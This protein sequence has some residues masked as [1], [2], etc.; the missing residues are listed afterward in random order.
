M[1]Y[2]ANRTE[3]VRARISAAGLERIDHLRGT[4]TRS[5]YIRQ[6][7]AIATRKE[8]PLHGP[9]ATGEVDF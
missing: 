6:A 8:G 2:M 1:R 7:L 4:W 5:E 9:A 3:E